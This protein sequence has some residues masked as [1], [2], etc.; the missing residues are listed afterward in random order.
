MIPAGSS[1]V[2]LNLGAIIVA[3]GMAG[4]AMWAIAIPPDVSFS[5]FILQ[6]FL[7]FLKKKTGPEIPPAVGT[8]GDVFGLYGLRA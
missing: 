5:T 8:I 7:D 3:G 2:E 1:T 4:V 6:V